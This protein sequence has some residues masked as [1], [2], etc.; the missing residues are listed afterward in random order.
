MLNSIE[1]DRRANLGRCPKDR[2]DTNVQNLV[3]AI[4]SCGVTFDIWEK[5]D[6]DG[7]ASGH[8]DFTSLMGS[9]KR[10]L[11]KHL[12][13]KLTGVINMR[14]ESSEKVIKLWEV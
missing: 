10:L 5:M 11:L 6:G 13:Q 4:R 14:V 12:P 2:T 9:D 8:F 7:K 1:D 3:L